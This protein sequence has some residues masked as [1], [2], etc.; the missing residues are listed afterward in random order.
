MEIKH[1]AAH[2]IY[3]G[4]IYPM[5]FVSF[6]SE[7]NCIGIHPLKEEIAATS[8]LNG[9]LMLL[10]KDKVTEWYGI[11]DT[12]LQARLPLSYPELL[13]ILQNQLPYTFQQGSNYM[14]IH[15]QLNPFT[16][17]ELRTDNSGS[18]CYIK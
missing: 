17:T 9:V 12:C 4:R 5:S 7:G 3:A 18:N 15:L 14:L 11:L 8:F 13:S 1:W 2:Y 6:D 10:P 16:A